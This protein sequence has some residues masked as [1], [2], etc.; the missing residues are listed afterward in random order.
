MFCFNT[1]FFLLVVFCVEEDVFVM[2][3]LI[4]LFLFINKNGRVY[5][6]NILTDPLDDHT[7]Q[8]EKKTQL[9]QIED[10]G[11]R[12]TRPSRPFFSTSTE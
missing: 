8:R 7:A 2:A 9:Q 10:D 11:N 5:L 3:L 1:L 4:P 12:Q 6:D